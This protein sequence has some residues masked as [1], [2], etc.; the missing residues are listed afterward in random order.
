MSKTQQRGIVGVL[1]TLIW[2]CSLCG[3]LAVHAEGGLAISGDFYRQ[4]F[5]LPVGTS[6]DSPGV[7]VVVFNTSDAAFS[8]VM[9][10]VTPDGVTLSF[11]NPE[12]TLEA[13]AQQKVEVSIEVGVEAT[14][15]DYELTV[16]AEAQKEATEGIQLLG[17][18]AQKAALTITGDVATVSVVSVSPSGDPIPSTLQLSRV[19]EEQTFEVGYSEEGSLEARVAPGDYVVT[20]FLGGEQLAEERFSVAADEHKEVSL[21]LKTVYIEG[22]GVVPNY[23]AQS[24]EIAFAQVVYTI[25]NV[26]ESYP[27]TKAVLTVQRDGQTIDQVTVATLSTL[28]QGRMGMSYSY[29][30]ATGWAATTYTF[31]LTLNIGGEDYTSSPETALTVAKGE[32]AGGGLSTG[33]ILGIAGGVVVIAVVVVLIVLR[34]RPQR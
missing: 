3:G 9:R 1:A 12:F 33:L 17:A 7:F 29:I 15:G 4:E 25:N 6:L 22:F 11:S 16:V 24:G 20:A 30:P 2:V 18:A 34:K 27:E 28:E 19:V 21:T 8:V 23:N 5:N 32:V 14:P 13:G 26:F 10:G 31:K